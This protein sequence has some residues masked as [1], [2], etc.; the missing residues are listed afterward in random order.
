MDSLA[1]AL[2]CSAVG[3]LG[4][5][6][7]LRR[8]RRLELAQHPAQPEPD[9]PESSLLEPNQRDQPDLPEKAEARPGAFDETEVRPIAAAGDERQGHRAG[10]QPGRSSPKPVALTVVI[11][12]RNE[13][14]NLGAL[15]GSLQAQ[16]V[17]AAEVLVVDDGSEDGTA[18]VAK[19][20]GARV[21]VP[22]PLPAGWLG[23]SWACW[24]GAAAAAQPQL[25][26]LDADIVLEPQALE[27]LSTAA[28]GAELLSVQPYHSMQ[29]HYERLSAVFNIVVLASVALGGGAFGPCV[30]CRK[31]DYLAAGG[32]AAV[33]GRVLDNHALSGAF[34]ARG[35]R[36]HSRSGRGVM[37]FRM[38]PQGLR[39]L[40]G[41]WSKSFA[42]GAA[43]TPPPALAVIVLWLAG[44][45][46]A[47]G[48]AARALDEPS[49]AAAFAA[50]LAYAAH[51]AL[52]AALLRRAGRFGRWPALLY[53]LPLVLFFAVFARSAAQTFVRRRVSW[54]GRSIATGSGGGPD[55][56]SA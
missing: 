31:Q 3:L 8:M 35:M 14:H 34:R 5:W 55:D 49:A 10:A 1:F 50:G 39:Q 12:A 45:A 27:R 53:P 20:L 22:G 46:S 32:H 7:M 51:A 24:Q 44:A 41:G 21:V 19:R 42:S 40:L 17:P 26:F 30:M 56:A 9:Q 48:L 18:E 25:L 38:Y 54:K 23:K 29:H 28:S 13:A 15:L 36:V 16:R 2:G 6:L 33:K 43:A 4:G 11:P 47:A 37:R 52:F